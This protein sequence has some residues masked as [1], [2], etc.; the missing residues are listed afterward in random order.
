VLVFRLTSAHADKRDF[1]A[2][3]DSA[4]Q[5]FFGSMERGEKRLCH[6]LSSDLGKKV[7]TASIEAQ[8]EYPRGLRV[9]EEGRGK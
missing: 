7:K 1:A 3:P 6:A 9:T 2:K 5:N 8:V 4:S